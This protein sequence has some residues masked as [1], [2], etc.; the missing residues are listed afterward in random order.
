MF[1]LNSLFLLLLTLFLTHTLSYRRLQ[2]QGDASLLMHRQPLLPP[3]RRRR[4]GSFLVFIYRPLSSSLLSWFVPFA[5][6]KSVFPFLT[7]T[8]QK[9][10]PHRRFAPPSPTAAPRRLP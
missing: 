10:S 7:S 6:S 2:F 8:G 4:G 3:R 9:L 5:N 1:D